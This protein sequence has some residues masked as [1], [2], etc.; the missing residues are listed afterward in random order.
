MT[1]HPFWQPWRRRARQD[2]SSIMG[3]QTPGAYALVGGVLVAGAVMGLAAGGV[4]RPWLFVLAVA[5]NGVAAV[6]LLAAPED[7]MEWRATT[8]AVVLPPL[9]LIVNIPAT[10]SRP[11][12]ADGVLSGLVALV[13]AFV[14]VRG[15]VAAAWA[16][17]ALSVAVTL[18]P[19]HWV[20]PRPVLVAAVMPNFAVLVIATLFATI[21]RPRAQQIFALQRRAERQ[22]A[23]EAASRAALAVRDQ[24]MAYL[25]ERAR[26]L[27]QRIATGQPLGDDAVT[28]C[29]LVE[30]ALRDRIRAPGLDLP[31][32]VS[33]TRAA[34]ARGARVVLLDDHSRHGDRVDAALLGP[35]REV[36]SEVLEAAHGGCDVTV[37]LL[38]DSRA[39]QATVTV[40]CGD[41]VIRWAFDGSGHRVEGPDS[42][43]F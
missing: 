39:E 36:V 17:Y 6:C 28:D 19:Q 29:R 27:L 32:V 18:A 1:E 42:A 33:A 12:L 22:T 25:D 3:M 21:V 4:D 5:L 15:R 10:T 14:C 16:G 40:V 24:Q 38:P 7:P 43:E 26:P 31:E 41:R 9:A 8:V 2:A 35:L 37:R 34:R 20:G 11:G 30:A 23:A 13:L